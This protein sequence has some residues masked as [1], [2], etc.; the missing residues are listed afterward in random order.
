[1]PPQFRKF[2]PTQPQL[3]P[4]IQEL[5]NATDALSNTLIDRAKR[6][7]KAEADIVERQRKFE[8]EERIFRRKEEIK[9]ELN[10][11]NATE[12]LIQRAKAAEAAK[13]L[14]NEQLFNQLRGQGGQVGG[15]RFQQSQQVQDPTV[16]EEAVGQ[17]LIGRGFT[18]P[19]QSS[20]QELVT[21]KLKVGA[22]NKL[23][24]KE[25][26]DIKAKS[27]IESA[28]DQIDK[29]SKIKLGVL[30]SGSNLS[31][32]GQSAFDLSK[33]Y[34]DAFKEGG[35]GGAIQATVAS[36][37][38]KVGDLPGGFEVGGRFPSAGSFPGKR[39]ELILKMMPMLTQQP[40]KPEGSVRL[41][42]GILD[43]IGQTIPELGTA[44]KQARRQLQ[45]TLVSFYRFARAAE[46]ID[47]EFDK[48]FAGRSPDEVSDEELSGWIDR[49]NA[50]TQD[51]EIKGNERKAVDNFINTALKPIDEIINKKGESVKTKDRRQLLLE[52]AQRRGLR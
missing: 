18:A 52:E 31:L 17:S 44:P 36:L 20:Q 5:S 3:N 6:K 42:Q 25:I 40:T 11:P 28:A 10:K 27:R 50:K 16:Q 34:A 49:V 21:P 43:A 24:P 46:L 13:T 45:E 32:L 23:E 7:R 37:A 19:G 4:I 8:D 14:G 41:I 9:Q 51:I 33:V 22:F 29:K 2:T 38:E 12:Q 48:V 39:Q 35:A 30:V 1:M 26:V 15:Q 47:L